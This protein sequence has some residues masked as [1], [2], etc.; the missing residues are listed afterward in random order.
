RMITNKA[1]PITTPFCFLLHF[2][3]KN[4]ESFLRRVVLAAVLLSC[5]TSNLWPQFVQNWA[6]FSIGFPHCVQYDT[7]SPLISKT[8]SNNNF[9]ISS[10]KRVLYFPIKLSPLSQKHCKIIPFVAGMYC[11]CS[12]FVIVLQ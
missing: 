6:S 5:A 11:F 12:Y 10:S 3:Q 1:E 8:S 9:I 4:S 7:V 2:F